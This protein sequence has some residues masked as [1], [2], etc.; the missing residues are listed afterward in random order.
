VQGVQDSAIAC[1]SI[2]NTILLI[3]TPPLL[4]HKNVINHRHLYRMNKEELLPFVEQF[5]NPIFNLE[6]PN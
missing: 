4:S 3:C 2:V 6:N 5:V 1:P